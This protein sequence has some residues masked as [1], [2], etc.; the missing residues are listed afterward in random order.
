M[1]DA[2]ELKQPGMEVLVSFKTT[3]PTVVTPMLMPCIVG[4]C[5]QSVEV[6]AADAVGNNVLNESAKAAVPAFIDVTYSGAYTTLDGRSLGL[7]I[8]NGPVVPVVFTGTSISKAAVVATINAALESNNILDQAVA[9]LNTWGWVL[10]TRG[11]GSLQSIK[12]SAPA[13]ADRVVLTAFG[14]HEDRVYRG[15]AEYIQKASTIP[16]FGYPDPRGNMAELVI[17]ASTVRGFMYMGTGAM[18]QEMYKNQTLLRHGVVGA[19]LH[20]VTAIAP[21]DDNDG[22]SLTPL[23]R[24]TGENF[25]TECAVLSITGTVD[26]SLAPTNVNSETVILDTGSGEQTFTFRSVA[27]AADIVT[28]LNG[29]FGDVVTFSLSTTYLKLDTRSKGTDIYLKFTGGTALAHLGIDTHL[30]TEFRGDVATTGPLALKPYRPL[31]GDDLYVNGAR[32]GRI[33]QVAPGGVVTDLK[34]DTEVPVVLGTVW[35]SYYIVARN[36]PAPAALLATRP[37]PD[38]MVNTTTGAMTIKNGLVRNTQGTVTTASMRMYIMYK[39]LRKDVT[40]KSRRKPSLLR[41]DSTDKL[42]SL[43]S[44]LNSTN[45]LGLATYYALLNSSNAQVQALGVDAIGADEP[46]GTALAYGRAFTFLESKEVYAIAPLSRAKAVCDLGKTHADTMSEPEN[47]GERVV[48]VS[49]EQPTHGVDN[50]VTSGTDGN[51]DGSLPKKFD[52][53]IANLPSLLMLAGID[54]TA[55]PFAVSVGLYLDIAGDDKRYSV[56]S[57]SGSVLTLRQT[58]SFLAGENDDAFYAITAIGQCIGTSF[59]LSVRGE[60]LILVDGTQDKDAIADTYQDYGRAFGSRRLWHLVLDKAEA[61]IGGLTMELPGYYMCAAY[62]GMIGGQPPQQSFTNFP[63]TGFTK[64]TGTNDFFSKRQLNRIA[65]GGNTIIIQDPEDTGPIF[66]RMALTTDMTS[67][68]TR[69]DSITKCLDFSCKFWRIAVRN[70]I[71]RFNITQGYLDTLSHVLQGCHHVLTSTFVLV[72]AETNNIIQDQDN[73]D[74]VIIDVTVD[75]PYPANYIQM[76]VIV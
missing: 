38:L 62:A 68:E 59:A 43:I 56:S 12:V 8:N 26:L 36:L 67:V 15:S 48:I 47:K 33:V 37:N 71:G 10:R 57:V 11:T 72:D 3:S 75:V 69:T 17:D 42:S 18:L 51:T 32:V 73:P 23:V 66:A 58:N 74:S 31:P 14:M 1:A 40:V 20:A 76:N 41:L 64:A 24:F 13:V 50:L 9:E 29:A 19:T 16:Q 54:P 35:T 61:S 7:E 60:A 39:A 28:Q 25:T 70:Y 65:V 53:G 27:A 55:L 21:T 22:D 5:F 52:T 46:E 2:S 45:P 4:P 44:P 34:I 6:V 30:N 49:R 63:I